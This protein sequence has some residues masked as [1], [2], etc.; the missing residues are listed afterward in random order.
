VRNS[1]RREYR[2]AIDY[3]DGGRY[4]SPW[5]DRRRAVI[6]TAHRMRSQLRGEIV[7]VESRYVLGTAPGGQEFALWS[8]ADRSATDDARRCS[9]E[10]E[11]AE[12]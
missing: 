1:V 12:S 3:C 9:R 6:D 5:R 8:F 4:Q 2:M 7:V 11:V 10:G